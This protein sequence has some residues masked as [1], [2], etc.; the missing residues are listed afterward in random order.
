[1]ICI[2]IHTY[3]YLCIYIDIEDVTHKCRGYNYNIYIYI[4]L[5]NNLKIDDLDVY[6]AQ[7]RWY[8]SPDK[9]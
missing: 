1:M 4:N 2:K 9:S 7:Y 8:L 5:Y 6:S 3:F